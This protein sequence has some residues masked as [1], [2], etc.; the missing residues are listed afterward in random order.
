MSRSLLFL[1][2]GLLIGGIIHVAV[3][4]LLPG[5]ANRDSWS[6]A[7]RFGPSGAFHLLPTTEA[8]TE[9]LPDLD[10][11]MAHAVCRFSLADGP[12]RIA[13]TL[14]EGFWSVAIFSRRGLNLYSLNDRSAERAG[15]D[16]L[17]LT[18]EQ[19]EAMAED[20]PAA[21]EQAILVELPI[22]EGFAL[23]RAFVPDPSMLAPVEAA[24][25]EA[26]CDAPL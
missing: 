17:V 16:L 12:V 10:P 20:P 8:G 2:G 5:F 15:L 26:N 22:S 7:G 19:L 1:A 23:I 13:A 11:D 25:A 4:F 21:F 6:S 14:P 18:P 3:V 9:P 24:L